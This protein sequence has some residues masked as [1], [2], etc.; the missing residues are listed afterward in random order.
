MGKV[1]LWTYQEPLI[2]VRVS[3]RGED[4]AGRRVLIVCVCWKG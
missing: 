3:P 1:N 2:S 4:R